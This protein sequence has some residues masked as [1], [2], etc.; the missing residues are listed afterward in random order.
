M[1][2]ISS[3]I[4]ELNKSA[5]E[6]NGSNMFELARMCRE[7]ADTIWQLRDD[8][9]QANAE[10]AKLRGFWTHDGTWHVE[11]PRLPEG[12]AVTMPDGRDREVRSVR[13]WRYE[14]VRTAKRVVASN[15][16]TDHATGLAACGFCGGAIDFWDAWC[17]HC[18][19][20]MEDE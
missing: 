16:S 9:Q 1:S 5:D 3:L 4:D 12:I 6:W 13:A 7:A 15:A 2:I 17:R 14:P 10:N 20:R 8:L 18:G 11:L 19:A